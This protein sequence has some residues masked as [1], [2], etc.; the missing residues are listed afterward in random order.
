MRG[1]Y[2]MLVI[3]LIIAIVWYLWQSHKPRV[4]QKFCNMI[5]RIHADP[6]K[7]Y[8]SERD[9]FSPDRPHDC[10]LSRRGPGKWAAT[11]EQNAIA[12]ANGF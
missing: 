2:T 6:N 3:V 5:Q 12:V 9:N 4:V 10:E 8:L 7:P 11:T 1:S